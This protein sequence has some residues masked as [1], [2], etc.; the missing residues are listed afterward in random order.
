M[1]KLDSKKILHY[2]IKNADNFSFSQIK[3]ITIVKK[4]KYFRYM[5]NK[6]VVSNIITYYLEDSI[7]NLDLNKARLKKI[8]SITAKIKHLLIFRLQQDLKIII[9]IKKVFIYLIT[10]GLFTKILDYFFRISNQMWNLAGDNS[11]DLNYYSKRLILTTLYLKIFIKLIT[12]ANY[13]EENIEI[14][15]NSEL[16]KVKKFNDLKSKISLEE[17]TNILKR[18]KTD[19][20]PKGRGF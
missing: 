19:S 13:S 2:L 9:F 10:Q 15:V 7:E 17:I 5:D 14:D 4:N 16:L 6:E 8:S 20:R 3:E 11:T 1:N 18:F 12:S